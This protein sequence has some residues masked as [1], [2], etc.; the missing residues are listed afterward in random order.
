LIGTTFE[1][2]QTSKVY[3][4]TFEVSKTSKVYMIVIKVKTFAV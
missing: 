3:P 2:S 1:V 4:K